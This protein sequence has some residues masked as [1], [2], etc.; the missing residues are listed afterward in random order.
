MNKEKIKKLK[1]IYY[2]Y[3]AIKNVVLK[4]IFHFQSA[5]SLNNISRNIKCVKKKI[6]LGEVLNVVFV[7]QYIPGWNKLVPIYDKM[8]ADDRF[9]PIIVC[10]PM[11]IQNHLLMDD[12]A[13]D[14]YEYFINNGYSVINA[15]NEDGS[16]YSLAQLKPDYLF[17]SRPYDLTMPICYSSRKVAKYALICNVL[18][19]ASFTKD[20]QSVTLNKEY[21]TNV[22]CYFSVDQ[23]ETD[24]YKKRFYVGFKKNITKCFPYGAIGLEQM[25]ACRVDERTTNHNKT[26]IWTPRWSTDSL[27]GGSNFFNYKK[28]IFDFARNNPDVLFIIRP[29]PLMFS[30]FV[31]TGEMSQADVDE[32]KQFCK[33]ESN[34]ELD[35]EKEYSK[36][37]WNSDILITDVSSIVPEYFIT[38]KPI[39]YCHSNIDF[40]YSEAADAIVKSCYETSNSDE[41]MK[42]LSCLLRGEDTKKSQRE[43]VVNQYYS[44]VANNSKH[45]INALINME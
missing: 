3:K 8:R 31:K 22:Y 18:Y 20:M 7:I 28:L 30:N 35:E 19:G 29:H 44:D 2:P 14:T 15:L 37:F 36:E 4:I 41:L 45:I 16:W 39:I 12:K 32:L 6:N 23:G 33:S 21:F 24:Y 38:G 17:H 9:N 27:V 34:I 10:V 25:L 43:A 1:V 13:N 40:H 42:Y 5:I 26:V 11:N